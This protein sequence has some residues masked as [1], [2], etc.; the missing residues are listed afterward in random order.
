MVRFVT[1]FLITL[2]GLF[3]V[4]VLEPVNVAV[5]DPFNSVLAWTATHVINLFGG[6]A[7]SQGKVI[8]SLGTGQAVSIERVC[9]GIEPCIILIAAMVAFPAPLPHKAVGIVVG[10]LAVQMLNMVRIVSLYYLNQWD[11]TWFEWFHLYIW[12]ALM[13]LDALVVFLLW[14]RLM[15]RQRVAPVEAE[16][17]A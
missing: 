9:N 8:L 6:D 2:I 3:V 11:K 17:A 16:S 14:L 13:V 1:L 7:V 5:I 12:Q 4:E 15:P 10:T